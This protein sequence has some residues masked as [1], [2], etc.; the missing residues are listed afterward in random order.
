MTG[1]MS[2]RR[3][4]D[5][6]RM[7]VTYLRGHGYPDAR[8]RL[9]GNGQ[10]GDIDGVPGLVI[11]SKGWRKS[12]WPTW[13]AQTIT[14][15]AGTPWAVVR[16]VERVTDVGAWPCVASLDAIAGPVHHSPLSLIQ[17]VRRIDS[18]P[19]GHWLAGR[20]GYAAGRFRDLFDGTQ[21]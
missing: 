3:G 8:R 20:D 19:A 21:A 9:A 17:I 12:C 1:A 5:T 6:E 13:V 10:A 18:L 11:E 16:R 14:E 15:A 7:I 2:R 4:A